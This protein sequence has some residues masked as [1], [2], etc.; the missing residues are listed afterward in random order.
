MST[1][2]CFHEILA[3]AVRDN[4]REPLP[5]DCAA[6]RIIA[7]LL[8]AECEARAALLP[9]EAAILAEY[10]LFRGFIRRSV[11]RKGLLCAAAVCGAQKSNS[12]RYYFAFSTISATLQ[13]L[14][15][16]SFL[17]STILTVSPTP[18]SLFSS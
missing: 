12:F 9:V 18:H 2:N 8:S 6:A 11:A 10:Y 5:E 7:C 15:L 3:Q 17:V 1:Y 16:E 4:F 14:S 13:F